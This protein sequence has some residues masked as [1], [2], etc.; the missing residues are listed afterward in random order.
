MANGKTLDLTIRIAGKLDK[1]L[2][3][4]LKNAQ[5]QV[6]NLAQT[7]G[8]IG[9]VGLATIG[10]MATGAAFGLTNCAKEAAKLNSSMAPVIRYVDGL[11][12]S[13]GKVSDAIAYNGQTYQQ[14]YDALE[15]YI[16]TLSAEIPR[17]TEQLATMS[18][19][20]GQSG[21]DVEKQLNS[22]VLKDTAIV[23]T[24][25]DL[26]DQTAGDYVGKWENSFVKTVNGKKVAWEHSDVMR[27]MDQINYLGANYATTAAEIAESV[28]TSAS[29]GQMINIDPAATAAIATAMQASGVS[30]DRVGTSINRIY[31]N[32]SSGSSATKAQQET[33]Q[34]L[35]YTST[36][37][38]KSL[39]SDGI[40]TLTNVFT[41]INNLPQERKSATLH[42]LFGQWAI[43]GG[44]KITENLD[45]M[46]GALD[47]VATPEKYS[48]SM[49]REFI[50]QA[51]TN[52]AV[53]LM[54]DNAFT[55]FRQDIGKAFLPAKK[56]ISLAL[57][58][59]FNAIRSMP[60]LEELSIQLATMFSR[61]VRWATDALMNALP[62]IQAGLDYLTEHGNDV[63]RIFA[64]LTAL[65]ATMKFAPQIVTLFSDKQSGND[66]ISSFNLSGFAGKRIVDDAVGL[67]SSVAGAKKVN[68]TR[69]TVSILASSL[70]GGNGMK[71]TAQ[72]LD[73]ATAT[74]ERLS[75]YQG[76]KSV[77]KER[78]ENSHVGKYVGGIG[79]SLSALGQAVFGSQLS[80]TMWNGVKKPFS[81]AGKGLAWMSAKASTLGGAVTASKLGRT[82]GSGIKIASSGIGRVGKI[83]GAGLGLANQMFGVGTLLPAVASISAIIAVVSILDDRL[84]DV[85]ILVVD[86]F[87]DTGGEVFDSFAGKLKNFGA[88]FDGLFA[89]GGVANAMAPLRESIVNLFGDNSGVVFDGFVTILQSVMGVVGDLVAFSTGTVKPIIQDIFSFLTGTVLP[90]VVQMFI[91][92][93]PSI[94]S[95]ITSIGTVVLSI[96]GLITTGIQITGPIICGL[97]TGILGVASMVISVVLAL[98][99]DFSSSVSDV[100]SSVRGILDG[101]IQFI[102]GVFTGDWKR[103]WNGVK[104][105]FGNAFDALV[106][107]V[108]TPINGIIDLLN[109][110][111]DALRSIQIQVPSW[112]PIGAGAE[113]GFG[114]LPHLDKFANGGFTHGPSIAGEAGTEAVISFRPSDRMR[115]LGIWQ[116]AGAML[117]V[118]NGVQ[119]RSTYSNPVHRIEHLFSV[120][121]SA[122]VVD[123]PDISKFCPPEPS[124]GVVIHF[125]PQ[126]TIHG[127]ANKETVTQALV[128]SEQRLKRWTESNF[129]RL[130]KRM[131]RER[132]RR[133]Y[134]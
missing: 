13:Y 66:T 102:T 68:G 118:A 5:S 10:S 129:E 83:A 127:N 16:Q 101:L 14:N 100:F 94:A 78:A 1:S 24:A 40:G 29:I 36:G 53:D 57:I 133:A 35:G 72:L 65:F 22:G 19:A 63:L 64:D 103:A 41:A 4:T 109:G 3:A 75:G 61:G 125:S 92:S 131:E 93:A 49:T 86:V 25:M 81:V 69:H 96:L 77:L 98:F 48:G 50:I 6:S 97:I 130:Y 76:V 113:L 104:D 116:R 128:E 28:N 43:E 124:G 123:V 106:T 2:T 11:A 56:E 37:I 55:A 39:Q 30:T 20:L 91:A 80:E 17:T 34:S 8:R 108:K 82:A 88:F 71:G 70:L 47:A 85:R 38:A 62:T 121:H 122:E 42:T 132:I 12:D 84:E 107:L 44:T 105:I 9:T 111:F 51:D 134:T 7:I 87:G 89:D 73:V 54:R 26:D 58:D 112:S 114:G 59:F 67:A 31:T 33:W 119:N 32:M 23:A 74:P 110:L 18:A 21:F 90:T 79:T 126:I 95:I 52:E 99:A 117:G 120:F 46:L 15:G 27:L 45:L 115:N 60:E